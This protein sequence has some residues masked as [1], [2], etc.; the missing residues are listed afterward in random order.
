[1]ILRSGSPSLLERTSASRGQYFLVTMHR[2]ENVDVEKRLRIV[3]GTG[4]HSATVR[5]PV[6]V[7]THPH[8]RARMTAFD[9]GEQRTG[10]FS[11]A[12]RFLRFY[13]S[14]TERPL[15]PQRQRNRTGGVLHLSGC[16]CDHP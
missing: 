5:L 13:H 9:I 1:M 7:S 8:T 10:P 15:R 3:I 6:I 16:Q 14:R 4:P 12:L 2:A 11:A